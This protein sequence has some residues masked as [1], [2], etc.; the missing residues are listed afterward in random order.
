[1]H[2]A[3]AATDASDLVCTACADGQFSATAGN[4]QCTAWQTCGAGS[5]LDTEGTRTADRQCAKCAAGTHFSPSDS[6]DACTRCAAGHFS[7]SEGLAICSPWAGSC[8]HG[9][10]AAQ[11][12]RTAHHHCGSCDDGYYLDGAKC[13][14]FGGHCENGALAQQSARAVHNHCGACHDGHYLLATS[15]AAWGGV[16]THGTLEAQHLRKTFHHCGSCDA[17]YYLEQKTCLAWQGSCAHGTM[18]GQ[19]K[20]TAPNH[21]G[22]CEAGYELEDH[23]GSQRCSE[24]GAGEY[25]GEAGP[26]ACGECPDGEYR[27]E[28]TGIYH[29]ADKCFPWTTCLSTEHQSAA[30]TSASDRFCLPNDGKFEYPHATMT[31]GEEFGANRRL[32]FLAEQAF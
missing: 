10:L 3:F 5:G 17:G 16:C 9:A 26:H 30:P 8:A 11:A 15:C 2:T 6:A 31:N 7:A 24:C 28:I 27:N 29:A 21:C 20:R 18:I 32:T 13:L 4:A 22:S 14:P 25:K 23:L 1:M 12:Q 19:E